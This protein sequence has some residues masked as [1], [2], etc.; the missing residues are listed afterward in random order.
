MEAGP[1]NTQPNP[2]QRYLQRYLDEMA[3][4]CG[5]MN[6]PSQ[7]QAMR[8]L[9]GNMYQQASIRA[10]AIIENLSP[11]EEDALM[12][13]AMYGDITSPVV[14]DDEG[15]VSTG[16]YT[17]DPTGESEQEQTPEPPDNRY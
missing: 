1:S 7:P 4:Y 16:Y 3:R 5:L 8:T 9:Y 10:R 13:M 6:D 2:R 15:T 11:A 17:I 14:E 12:N